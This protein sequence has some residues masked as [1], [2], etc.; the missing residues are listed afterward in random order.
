M[1]IK[2][3]REFSKNLK[4][5]SSYSRGI[6]A[7]NGKENFEQRNIVGVFPLTN[8][9]PCNKT[10]IIKTVYT[11]RLVEQNKEAKINYA[12]YLTK[13]PPSQLVA[14]DELPNKCVEMLAI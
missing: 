12:H 10:A 4:N 7:N 1:T 2:I 3:Q 8:I 9:T 11:C 6:K 13:K 5:I 14:K